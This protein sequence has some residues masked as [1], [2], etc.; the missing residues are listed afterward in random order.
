M[1]MDWIVI[2]KAMNSHLNLL[3]SLLMCVV[4]DFTHSAP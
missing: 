3:G 2:I 1:D 4:P